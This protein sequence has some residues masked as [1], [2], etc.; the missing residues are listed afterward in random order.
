MYLAFHDKFI[1][2][3]VLKNQVKKDLINSKP[4]EI[5]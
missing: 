3:I 1:K 2:L 5:R 4:L